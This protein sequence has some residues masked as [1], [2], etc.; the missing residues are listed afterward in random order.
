MSASERLQPVALD[1]PKP[2]LES[3]RVTP[4]PQQP[5]SNL[6]AFYGWL[7]ENIPVNSLT[8]IKQS[9]KDNLP[10]LEK[11][12]ALIQENHPSLFET[13]TTFFFANGNAKPTVFVLRADKNS[14]LKA[15]VQKEVYELKYSVKW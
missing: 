7:G 2:K 8:E 10:D 15:V 3:E 12:L 9:L 11:Q 4:N 14:M 5:S 1:S 13:A 6:T